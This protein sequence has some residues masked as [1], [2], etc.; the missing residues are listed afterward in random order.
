MSLFSFV[1]YV[2]NVHL[3]III[4]IMIIR[5]FYYFFFVLFQFAARANNSHSQKE[6][7]YVTKCLKKKKTVYT[8]NKVF[9]TVKSVLSNYI[10][11][12]SV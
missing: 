2:R 12:Y 1:K 3:I 5:L 7:I 8:L 11:M 9:K 10:S 6:I 4:I